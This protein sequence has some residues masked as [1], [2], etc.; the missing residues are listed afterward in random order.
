[1]HLNSIDGRTTKRLVTVFN[2]IK[3]DQILSF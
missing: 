3:H 1:M 2:V